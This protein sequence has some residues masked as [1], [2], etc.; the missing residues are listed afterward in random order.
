MGIEPSSEAWEVFE[1]VLASRRFQPCIASECIP[2]HMV[3]VPQPGFLYCFS[4]ITRRT[5]VRVQAVPNS[6]ALGGEF[7]GTAAAMPS[8]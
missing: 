7:T 5:F 3:G 1:C 2:S 6:G 4:T 8:A